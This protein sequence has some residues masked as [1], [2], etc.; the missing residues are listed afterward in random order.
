MSAKNFVRIDLPPELKT[1]FRELA[2][3]RNEDMTTVLNREIAE[4]LDRVDWSDLIRSR[5]EGKSPP[6]DPIYLNEKV[7]E[8]EAKAEEAYS[9]SHIRFGLE[10]KSDLQK[11]CNL[12]GIVMSSLVRLMVVRYVE[13]SQS[14]PLS[15]NIDLSDTDT[16]DFFGFNLPVDIDKK[17]KEACKQKGI[18]K[19]RFLRLM[20]SQYL[21]RVKWND[22]QRPINDDPEFPESEVKEE[23]LE[24]EFKFTHIV[25]NKAEK[26]KIALV[27]RGRGIRPSSLFRLMIT[28]FIE[29][30]NEFQFDE[31]PDVARG[32]TT[33]EFPCPQKLYDLFDKTCAQKMSSA[34]V[35]LK[36]MLIEYISRVD[37]E[38][39][40]KNRK[41]KSANISSDPE[42]PNEEIWEEDSGGDK[43]VSIS[44]TKIQKKDLER[45]CTIRDISLSSLSRVMMGRYVVANRL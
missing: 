24:G 1:E 10:A 43:T 42:F 15:Q 4:Y 29:N 27:C 14:L 28:R 32:R 23:G 19:S 8:N 41:G 30:P 34:P 16:N 11:V 17:F 25:L 5:I 44:L 31:Q 40:R 38:S 18:S 2:F 26:N 21:E 33:V 45:I 3:R 37:W 39:L 13:K 9:S 12:R 20:A 36:Q 35:V 22:D 7:S 6:S